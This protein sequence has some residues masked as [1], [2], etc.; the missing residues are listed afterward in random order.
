[1]FWSLLPL[2]GFPAGMVSAFLLV[3]GLYPFFTHT[4]TIGKLGWLEKIIVTPTHHG[5]HH[6]SN[7]DYLDKNY[8]DM[9][10]I[11]DKFFG[12]FAEEKPDVKPVYGLTKPLKS[13]S[14]L[15]QHFHFWLELALNFR[16]ASGFRAKWKVLT[17]KP[18]ELDPRYRIVLERKLSNVQPSRKATPA[19]R[20]YIVTQTIFSLVLLCALALFREQIRLFPLILMAAFILV[21][22]INSGAILDQRRWNFLLEFVRGLIVLTAVAWM[23]PYTWVWQLLAGFVLLALLRFQTLRKL[24]L[25]YLYN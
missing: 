22:L 7:P 19:M 10:I 3:H 20:Q 5:V 17:G 4:Q 6:A 25:R 9:L 15:W 24:Y 8:G 14:F 23:Y 16:Y 18:E 21:S 11:W 1:V 12:T 13:H 2:A